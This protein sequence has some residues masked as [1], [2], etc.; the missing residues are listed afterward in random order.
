MNK[1]LFYLVVMCLLGISYQPAMGSITDACTAIPD[2]FYNLTVLW[3]GTHPEDEP[4]APFVMF[5]S[6]CFS[7]I[8]TFLSVTFIIPLIILYLF[9]E[10]SISLIT[11]PFVIPYTMLKRCCT[12]P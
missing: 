3:N 9:V 11:A 4:V 12:V 1:A 7:A 2:I 8:V 6:Y 5:V 10:S